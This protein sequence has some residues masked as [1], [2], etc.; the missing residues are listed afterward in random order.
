[1]HAYCCNP[2]LDCAPQ[3]LRSLPQSIRCYGDSGQDNISE[4][5]S[6]Q[7]DGVLAYACTVLCDGLL[8]LELRN[9]IHLGDGPRI[10]CC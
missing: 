8:L 7:Q 5:T 2:N 6:S 9:A 10:L 4:L 1:M 3:P